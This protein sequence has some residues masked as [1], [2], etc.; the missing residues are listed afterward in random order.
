M[1]SV[2]QHEDPLRAAE[3]HRLEQTNT[4]G[5]HRAASEPGP[6]RTRCSPSELR[7]G[8]RP[9]SPASTALWLL[10][11]NEFAAEVVQAEANDHYRDFLKYGRVLGR[12]G[13]TLAASIPAVKMPDGTFACLRLDFDYENSSVPELM[14]FG[15]SPE[16]DLAVPYIHLSPRCCSR[17]QASIHLEDEFGDLVLSDRS[18]YRSSCLLFPLE[19]HPLELGRYS[20]IDEPGEH[21]ATYIYHHVLIPGNKCLLNLGGPVFSIVWS[22]DYQKAKDH[23]MRQE[24]RASQRVTPAPDDSYQHLNETFIRRLPQNYRNVPRIALGDLMKLAPEIRYMILRLVLKRDTAVHFDPDNVREIHGK[25]YLSVHSCLQLLN[26]TYHLFNPVYSCVALAAEAAGIFFKQNWFNMEFRQVELFIW[27]LR[28]LPP[29][30]ELDVASNLARIRLSLPAWSV[31]FDKWDSEAREGSPGAPADGDPLDGFWSDVEQKRFKAIGRAL[32]TAFTGLV[33]IELRIYRGRKDE[34]K[35][36]EQPALSERAGAVMHCRRLLSVLG[37]LVPMVK[38]LEGRK[39]QV[40]VVL[41]SERWET[42]PWFHSATG[43][44]T[45]PADVEE[46]VTSWW[47]AKTPEDDILLA[48]ENVKWLAEMDWARNFNENDWNRKR[49]IEG[50][51][52]RRLADP[53]YRRGPVRFGHF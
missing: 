7:P 13:N 25:V 22:H 47:K 9:A 4:A 12:S 18:R 8:P 33:Q 11:E 28:N 50:A 27:T 40:R 36:A 42:K 31:A 19:D 51:Y 6:D 39:V 16:P 29:L 5:S 46:D 21:V 15:R 20:S 17:L 26:L 44:W 45:F 24:F 53:S 23:A 3:P 10:P 38:L 1:G 32:T 30:G 2:V 52:M 49:D 34:T 48:Y 37:A 43:F 35:T 41:L 14:R